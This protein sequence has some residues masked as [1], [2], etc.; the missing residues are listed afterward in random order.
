MHEHQSKDTFDVYYSL[1]VT[2][3]NSHKHLLLS[4]CVPAAHAWQ[5]PKAGSLFRKTVISV[6]NIKIFA[7]KNVLQILPV[8]IFLK[9]IIDL[10]HFLLC[11]PSAEV[12]DLLEAGYLTV[13]MILHCLY[14]IGSFDKALMSSRIKPCEALAEKLYI[15]GSVLKID[16]VEVGYLKLASGA[17]LQVFGIFYNTVVVEIK[18]GDTVI[19]LGRRRLFLY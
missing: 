6:Q 19:A 8:L 3:K 17:R 14:E 10:Q 18:A 15:E 16:A 4:S 2:V 12:C 13:L 1:I 11:D 5:R 7:V 9:D